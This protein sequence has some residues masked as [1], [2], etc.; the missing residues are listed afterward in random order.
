LLNTKKHILQLAWVALI[1]LVFG[2]TS[3]QPVSRINALYNELFLSSENLPEDSITVK[4]YY[5]Y[6]ILCAENEGAWDHRKLPETCYIGFNM[7]QRIGYKKGINDFIQVLQ[8]SFHQKEG[9]PIIVVHSYPNAVNRNTF[10]LLH[11]YRKNLHGGTIDYYKQAIENYRDRKMFKEAGIISFWNGLAFFDSEN[12]DKAQRLFSQSREYLNIASEHPYLL[13]VALYYG[14]SYYYSS[15]YNAALTEFDIAE[16]ECLTLNDTLAWVLTLYN[17]GETRMLLNEY[18]LALN[19]FRKAFDIEISQ[20]DTCSDVTGQLRI[21]RAF[22]AM[23]QFEQCVQTT[24]NALQRAKDKSDKSGEADALFLMSKAL[25]EFND[26]ASAAQYLLEF[27]VLRDSLFTAEISQFVNNKE[28]FWINK[29]GRQETYKAFVDHERN[30][31]FIELEKSKLTLWAV[32]LLA[33][34]LS[35][36]GL[37]LFQSNRNHKKANAYLSQLDKTRNLFFSIIAHDLRG[38]LLA[39]DYLLKPAIEKAKKSGETELADSLVEIESQNTRRKL[40]L[41]NLLFWASIQRGSIICNLQKLD[42]KTIINHTIQHFSSSALQYGSVVKALRIESISIYADPDMMDLILR[43]LIDNALKHGGNGINVVAE[44][45]IED[46]FL[47]ISISDNGKGISQAVIDRLENDSDMQ[48]L[49]SSRM[50]LAMIRY[51]VEMQGGKIKIEPQPTGSRIRFSIPI[52]KE[53]NKT[54]P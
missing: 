35:L 5:E 51:F 3:A 26:N 28:Y 4:K 41:D 38:P 42:L 31:Y 48:S 15:N 10:R 36:I 13:Q 52:F 17:R 22:F 9:L 6:S 53:Q 25:I 14:C 20:G 29:L 19:D 8:K 50:G 30:K 45:Q 39:T 43:N 1:Q 46:E 18:Q 47:W 23:K 21:A 27:I 2:T 44:T 32:L 33:I 40:L 16:K 37:L 54:K 7:S 12:F 49:G 34:I 24:E 11:Q